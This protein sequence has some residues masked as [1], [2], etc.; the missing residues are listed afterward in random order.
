MAYTTFV[1][2]AIRFCYIVRGLLCLGGEGFRVDV[3]I[4]TSSFISVEILLFFERVVKIRHRICI[5]PLRYNLG[6]QNC[7]NDESLP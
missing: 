7:R 2:Y 3:F 1:R 5:V 4:L 6:E